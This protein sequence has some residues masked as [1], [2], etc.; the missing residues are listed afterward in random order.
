VLTLQQMDTT[1]SDLIY[2]TAMNISP[3]TANVVPCETDFVIVERGTYE[4]KVPL[5][6]GECKARQEISEQDVQNLGRVADAFARTRI[7]PFIIF[8]KT[9]SFTPEEVARCQAAQ[10]RRDWRVIL[11]SDRELEP[12]FVYERTATEFKIRSTAVSL[13]DLARATQD[14]YFNPK[15]AVRRAVQG[16]GPPE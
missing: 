14:I 10:G 15:P 9:T 6:I 13:E 2:T 16:D 1:L 3:I 12:Y 5:A 7:E 11:L 8:S 4:L